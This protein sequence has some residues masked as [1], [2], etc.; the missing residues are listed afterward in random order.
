MNDDCDPPVSEPP[1]TENEDHSENEPQ[2]EESNPVTEKSRGIVHDQL[3]RRLTSKQPQS[4]HYG[5]EPSHEEEEGMQP[6]LKKARVDVS[7]L[8]HDAFLVKA[9]RTKEKQWHRLNGHEKL[10]SLKP[11]PNNG[12]RGRKMQ[13]R[14]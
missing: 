12:T 8:L 5:P 2:V 13:Q 7:E 9:A 14:R 4:T 1:V 11:F 3:R 6:S 10:L